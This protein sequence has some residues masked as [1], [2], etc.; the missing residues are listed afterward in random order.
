MTISKINRRKFTGYAA[1]VVAALLIFRIPVVQSVAAD[2]LIEFLRITERTF[3]LPCAALDHDHCF[4]P[5]MFDSTS[6]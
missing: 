1:V 4:T 6:K 2:A 5:D 3:R